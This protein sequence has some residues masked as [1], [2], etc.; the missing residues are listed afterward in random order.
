MLLY[1]EIQDYTHTVSPPHTLM[2]SSHDHYL[3]ACDPFLVL[4]SCRSFLMSTLLD[5]AGKVDD[6]ANCVVP[7]PYL[8]DLE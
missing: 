7:Y 6:W 5:V 4:Y 8:N 3:E 2:I 1:G